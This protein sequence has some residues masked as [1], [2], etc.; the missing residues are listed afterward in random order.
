M[1]HVI[2]GKIEG[3]IKVLERRGRRFMQLL[4]DLKETRKYWKFKE[5]AADHNTTYMKDSLWKRIW[6][7]KTDCIIKD[8]DFDGDLFIEV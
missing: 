6:T 8:Y 3:N 1:K 5:E 7:C 4:D 2:D